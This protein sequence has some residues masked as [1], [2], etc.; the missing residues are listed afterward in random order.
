VCSAPLQE[1]LDKIGKMKILLLSPWFPWPPFDGARIRIF[2][3]LRD[4]SR[5]H[6]VTLLANVGHPEE[7]NKAS[8]L[9][10]I[11]ERVETTVLSYRPRAVLQR[12]VQGALL[13]IPTVQSVYYDAKLARRVRAI[14]S[15]EK[16]DI[17]QIELSY[18]AR[19]VQAISPQC[20]AKKVLS[21]HN[22]ESIRYEREMHLNL[23]HDRR[24]AML[25]DRF[26]FR[27]WEEQAL[28]Q[29]DGVITVSDLE[30]VWVQ[31]RAP[32][33]TV[34]L[35]P[36]G[37]DTE[38]FSPYLHA[39][40]SERN[41][42]VVFTG[43]MSYPPNVDAVIWFCDAILPMLRRQMP[44]L[45]FKIVGRDPHPKVCELGQR[46]GVCVTGEVADVRPYLAEA[47]AM[48]VPLRSGGGT[49]LKILQAMAMAC[50]VISTSLG[51]EGLQVTPGENI[52]MADNAEHFVSHILALCSAPETADRLGQAG[53]RLVT[54]T[55]DWRRCL[56]GLDNF[57]ATL[58]G[59]ETA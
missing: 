6:R 37:V 45:C 4:L 49:R 39:P 9:K 38:G 32:V 55:Y 13:G 40:A 58:L 33:A 22:V 29:F 8:V 24:L 14:T 57:Y 17:V 15:Q 31:H 44:H 34:A 2:E 26:L 36:N 3:T 27:T 50:P 28:Q 41:L 54:E 10:E 48:V 11:C 56:G 25:W 51:A 18:A 46:Q 30:R 16:Y 20:P 5:R 59:S 47:L 42:S 43:A 7:A 53:R 1:D 19:Y 35:V 21:M 52:L 12:L 23:R